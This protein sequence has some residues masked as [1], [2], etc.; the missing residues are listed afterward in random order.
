MNLTVRK[1]N[2]FYRKGAKT[3]SLFFCI[4]FFT[5]I[6]FAQSNKDSLAKASSPKLKKDIFISIGYGRPNFA[7]IAVYNDKNPGYSNLD[8]RGAW[9]LKGEY[10]G[11]KDMISIGATIFY[12]RVSYIYNNA[13]GAL[14][15]TGN[16]NKLT[17][18]KDLGIGL[19]YN[20]YFIHNEGFNFYLG[21]GG[22][23]QIPFQ[24]TSSPIYGEAVLGIRFMLGENV[25]LYFELGAGKTIGQGGLSVKF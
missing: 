1:V 16:T 9:F 17:D 6:I 12:S 18:R 24:T 14:G 20:C 15:S 19:R 25:G 10:F 2:R 8:D 5:Q 13:Y 7:S 4:L 22:G 23:G 3:L 21:L 11:P